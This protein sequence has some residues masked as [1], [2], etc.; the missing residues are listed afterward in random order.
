MRSWRLFAFLLERARGTL[1]LLVCAGLVGGTCSVALVALI[2]RALTSK[3]GVAS[4]LAAGFVALTMGKLLSALAAQLLLVRFTQGTILELSLALARKLLAAPLRLVE[5]R[6][7]AQLLATLTDDVSAVTWAV[8]CIPQ[9]VMNGAIVVGCSLYLAWLSGPLF[10]AL[11]TATV[12]GAAAYWWQHTHAFAVIHRAREERATL[13]EHY[14]SLMLGL[15]ELMLHER[16]RESFLHRDVHAAADAYR[17]SNLDATTRYALAEAWI[18]FLYHV[19]I[20]VALFAAPLVWSLSAEVLTGYVFALLYLMGPMWSVIGTVPVVARGHVALASIEQLGAELP[21]L[22][23]DHPASPG[24]PTPQ[25][26]RV[27]MRGLSFAY[28]PDPIAMQAFELG[29]IELELH[30]GE[31]L[32]VVGGN[33]SGKST[34][35][36]L[37]CGLYPGKSGTIEVDGVPVTDGTRG[38][39]RELFSVVFSDYYLFRALHGIDSHVVQRS[40]QHYLRQLQ[41][42]QKVS[43]SD[44]SYSTI[45]LSQGQRKRLALMT[46]YLEDR[47]IMIFD[48]WAADQDPDYKRIFY[49]ELVPDLRARGKTVVVITHDDRYFHLGDRVL[50]LEDG[51]VAS[52]DRAHA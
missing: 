14:R 46:A 42:D 31:L 28:E 21:S 27:C 40:A 25:P 12:L 29:P 37:L 22:G 26:P 8:Q 30:P 44:G 38:A 17:R 39:Y 52:L 10:L 2:S 7:N 43:L 6:G 36:K 49:T 9:L 32:F 41:L 15:K 48:E 33:G 19:L 4:W 18:G 5:R 23:A 45:D 24:A 20:A 47:P 51:R 13:F 11:G 1:V 35:V 16:R 3:G 34:F 50:K